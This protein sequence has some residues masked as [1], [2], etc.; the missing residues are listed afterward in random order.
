VNDTNA[1]C[2]GGGRH[3]VNYLRVKQ[4]R[5]AA[6]SNT[7]RTQDV[8]RSFHLDLVHGEHKHSRSDSERE[9]NVRVKGEGKK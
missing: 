8:P 6:V 9:V 3:S 5:P 7:P 2:H 1:H 4:E